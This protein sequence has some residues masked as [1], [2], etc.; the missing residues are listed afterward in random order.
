[1]TTGCRRVANLAF[2]QDLDKVRDILKT[3]PIRQIPFAVKTNRTTDFGGR[4]DWEIFVPPQDH[5]RAISLLSDAGISATYL[6][7][8]GKTTWRGRGVRCS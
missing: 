7:F 3:N 6:D 1:M 4:M 5:P 8:S 2:T